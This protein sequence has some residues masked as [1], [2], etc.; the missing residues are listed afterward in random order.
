MKLLDDIAKF[1]L[2]LKLQ[3][4]DMFLNSSEML[5]LLL[6]PFQQPLN[7]LYTRHLSVNDANCV[8]VSCQSA[9]N[10][11][12]AASQLH[13]VELM[14]VMLLLVSIGGLAFFAKE[15]PGL[16]ASICADMSYYVFGVLGTADCQ[17]RN[18]GIF[19]HFKRLLI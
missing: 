19:K 15:W 4:I 13:Y 18:Q 14:A 1:L 6:L 11:L 8:L 12:Y 5:F 10:F 2:N 16:A 3:G 17:T 9:A 7:S